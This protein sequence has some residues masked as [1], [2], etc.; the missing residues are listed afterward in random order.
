MSSILNFLTGIDYA[1][2]VK[3]VINAKKDVMNTIDHK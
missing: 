2:P 3:K 1:N